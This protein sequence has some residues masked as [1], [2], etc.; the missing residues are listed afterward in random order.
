MV[1]NENISSQLSTMTKVVF[2]C[3]PCFPLLLENLI[4]R[5][6]VQQDIFYAEN[7][8]PPWVLATIK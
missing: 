8:K 2:P 1:D 6:N 4:R 5:V 7:Y 3:N